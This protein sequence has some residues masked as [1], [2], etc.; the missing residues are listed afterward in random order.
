[1]PLYACAIVGSGAEG[2][3]FRPPFDGDPRI[4]WI[5]LGAPGTDQGMGLLYL[6]EATIDPRLEQIGEVPG[7]RPPLRVRRRLQNALGIT[8]GSKSRSPL[9]GLIAETMLL[10]GRSDGRGW[11][12]LRPSK[13]RQQFEIYLGALGAI[14]TARAPRAPNSQSYT[15]TWPTNGGITSGQNLTWTNLVNVAEV[16]AGRVRNAAAASGF[17]FRCESLLDTSNQVHSA[18]F[19]IVEGGAGNNQ[20]QMLARLT[21]ANNFYR[22]TCRRSSGVGY[23]RDGSKRI[24]SSN[25]T[26]VTNSASDPG[27][28][29]AIAVQIDGSTMSIT[30]GA[31]SNT[32][33]DGTPQNLTEFRCGCD[34]FGQAI[35]DCTLDNHTIA[36]VV[37]GA[38]A[39]SA[40]LQ[41][42]VVGFSYF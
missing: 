16:S 18:D 12:T 9:A 35:G 37:S 6:P 19:T 2:D 3:P 20:I 28:S 15:E 38:A 21:D 8:L 41:E 26:I 32:G 29:G 27:G 34:L 17:T 5:C 24:A 7:E 31:Y 33:T 10:H 30:I 1:M 22:T 13:V 39:L 42:P 4:G 14:W 25:T 11:G 36:D 40:N 23:V